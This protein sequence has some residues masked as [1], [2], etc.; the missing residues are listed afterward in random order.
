VP[1][2]LR[3]P[4]TEARQIPGKADRSDKVAEIKKAFLDEHFSVKEDGTPGE[5]SDSVEAR[6]QASEAFRTL[7]K[8][9]TRKLI[10]EKGQARRRPGPP[11]S[12]PSR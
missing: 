5:F 9:V 7:E 1:R 10:V 11:R 2:G 12:A 3:G 6:K 8:K 4:L